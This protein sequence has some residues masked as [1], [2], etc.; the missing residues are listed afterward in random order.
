MMR[1]RGLLALLVAV[2]VV[3]VVGPSVTPPDQVYCDPLARPREQWG[4]DCASAEGQNCPDGTEEAPGECLSPNEAGHCQCPAAAESS[5]AEGGGSGGSG[6]GGSSSAAASQTVV[7]TVEQ[8]D[9][10]LSGSWQTHRLLATLGDSAQNVY[11]MF[12]SSSSPL[13]F[14]PAYQVAAPFGADIGGTDPAFWSLGDSD[15]Q[16]DSWLTVGL[17][18]GMSSG[19]ISSIGMDWQAWTA[20]AGLSVDDGALFWMVP[21]DGPSGGSA[22]VL[23][24]MTVPSDFTSSTIRFGLQG[25]SSAADADDWQESVEVSLSSGGGGGGGGGGA[26]G[27]EEPEQVSAQAAGEGE[28]EGSGASSGSG[29]GSG[30]SP[31]GP[32]A[33]TVEQ[34]DASLSGS[35][36]T[37]RLLA[38]LGDSAQNVYSMF[39]SSSSPLAFPPAYQVAAPFGADIGGTDPAFWSLGD[40]DSQFDSWLT[41]GLSEGMSSGEISSIGMDWQAWTADAGL[42][43]DD[44]A[45]FWMVP[46]DGP[47]GGS[48]V[49][50]AQMTVP[51]DFTSS[52]IRFGLQ[53]RSSAADADDWQESVEVSLSS[54][55]GG[56]GGGG[57]AGGGEEPEQVSAQAAGEGEG[58]GASSGSGSGSSPQQE[59]EGTGSSDNDGSGNDENSGSSEQPECSSKGTISNSPTLCSGGVGVVCAFTCNTGYTPTGSHV[60]STSEDGA[61]FWTGGSC[62]ADTPAPDGAG[63]GEEDSGTADTGSGSSCASPSSHDVSVCCNAVE[64]AAAD[65]TYTCSST[66]SSSSSISHCAIGYYKRTASN[67]ADQCVECSSIEHAHADA[68]YECSSATDSHVSVCAAGYFK[69]RAAA[70]AATAEVCTPF[71][72]CGANAAEVTDGSSERDRVC[73]CASG[74]FSVRAGGAAFEDCQAWTACAEGAEL[75]LVGTHMHDQA[76]GVAVVLTTVVSGAV[77]D[78]AAFAAEVAA[79]SGQEDAVRTLIS[80]HCALPH[81]RLCAIPQLN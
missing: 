13:A 12:G 62:E 20:D 65:A 56:G 52:T 44:G 8:L 59:G 55:G 17:S 73:K 5:Q 40:S 7:V 28:G 64:H 33:V 63:Q 67:Q 70:A 23:A 18:E 51:S 75:A 10:S 74:F 27:G 61:L 54:G 30:S 35:W 68:A 81:R 19:E 4:D 31:L 25:R 79:A 49:V 1:G 50:L 43:V 76:C 60:C 22:V 48:A 46:D 11:S 69:Q 36:Q 77:T 45:L 47:S 41:V 6:S 29:S 57:G 3:T 32:V 80:F 78:V 21:D 39:G 72:S 53:G 14:P 38:T 37:H 42:S 66:S 71:S 34:L 26:G 2:G 16:F 58:S 9:A 15:S 24:Q